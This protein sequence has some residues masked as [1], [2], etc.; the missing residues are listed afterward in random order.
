MRDELEWRTIKK[1]INSMGLT[2]D[3]TV[4]STT[5]IFMDL[6]I[7]ILNDRFS[8]TIYSKPMALHLYIPSSSC[9]APGIPTSLVFGHTLRVFRLCSK[10]SDIN[11]ELNLFY[12]QLIARGYSPNTILPLLAKAE[13]NARDRV[14]YKKTVDMNEKTQ[15]KSEN[16]MLFFHLPFHPSNPSSSHIQKIWRDI[17][18]TPIDAEKLATLTNYRGHK[19]PIS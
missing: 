5:A 2:W 1:L 18:A 9:H 15:D 8:T 6:K 10:N 4:R 12:K 3:F 19:I 7:S 16:D 17:I 11:K 13:D 14:A